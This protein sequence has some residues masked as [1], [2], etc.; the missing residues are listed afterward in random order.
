MTAR[1]RHLL[2]LAL[3]AAVALAFLGGHAAMI[4]Q[5]SSRALMPVAALAS[6]VVVLAVLWHLGLLG[7]L[8]AL[9]RR[10]LF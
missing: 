2:R 5:V 1:G 4:D 10:R 8:L 3:I 7:A 6:G 9:L